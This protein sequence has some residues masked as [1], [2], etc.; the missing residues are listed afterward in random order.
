MIVIVS[1]HPHYNAA[2]IYAGHNGGS[3]P[4]SY[5]LHVQKRIGVAHLVEIGSLLYR[6][7]HVLIKAHGL[8]ILLVDRD[9]LNAIPAD[10]VVKKLPPKSGTA[11]LR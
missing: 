3:L 11:L 4:A 6:E 1:F 8:R 10:A 9:L 2:T 5:P 7:A